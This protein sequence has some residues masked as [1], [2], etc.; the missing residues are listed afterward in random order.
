MVEGK[1][2]R[3]RCF[4]VLGIKGRKALHGIKNIAEEIKAFEQKKRRFYDTASYHKYGAY[5]V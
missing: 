5:V 4:C 3:R 1:Y 2:Y